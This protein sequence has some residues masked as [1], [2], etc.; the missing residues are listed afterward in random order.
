MKNERDLRTIAMAASLA[1]AVLMLVGKLYA[2]WITDSA[3][4]FSDT[5][6]T[7]RPLPIHSAIILVIVCDLGGRCSNTADESRSTVT[8]RAIITIWRALV[9][10]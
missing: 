9:P 6:S 5:K 1:V 4:I 7:L 2:F 8:G 10:G 3:A